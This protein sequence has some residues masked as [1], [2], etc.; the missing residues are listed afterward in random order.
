MSLPNIPLHVPARDED[1]TVLPNSVL[2]SHC[3]KCMS[4]AT[5]LAPAGQGGQLIFRQ[6]H[7]IAIPFKHLDFTRDCCSSTHR[8]RVRRK[9]LPNTSF[10][11]SSWTMKNVRVGPAILVVVR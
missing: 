4:L 3:S 7:G 11:A 9:S 1:L 2:D 5:T 10:F 8:R 6:E